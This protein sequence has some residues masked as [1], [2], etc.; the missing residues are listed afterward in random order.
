MK[1]TTRTCVYRKRHEKFEIYNDISNDLCYCKGVIG[2]FTALGLKI[3]VAPQ[4]KQ[5]SIFAFGHSVQKKENY[6]NFKEL[7]DKINYPEFKWDVCGDFKMLA[8]IFGLQGRG[9]GGL[10]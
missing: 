7:L 2:L 9:G 5:I 8:F 4:L 1:S 10:H 6:D 3:S